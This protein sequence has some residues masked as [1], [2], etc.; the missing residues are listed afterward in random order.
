[1]SPILK[2]HQTKETHA[3]YSAP[4]I[5]IGFPTS[6]IS[7]VRFNALQRDEQSPSRVFVLAG[8]H[9]AIRV[10]LVQLGVVTWLVSAGQSAL[11]GFRAAGCWNQQSMQE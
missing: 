11:S 1:M 5:D 7:F 9:E 3:L 10:Q 2:S 6:E 4:D 8:G